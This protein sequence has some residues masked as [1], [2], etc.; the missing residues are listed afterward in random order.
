MKEQ[1]VGKF[2]DDK[3]N[4]L[5]SHKGRKKFMDPLGHYPQTRIGEEALDFQNLYLNL[6][7]LHQARKARVEL[8]DFKKGNDS[9]Q[10]FNICIGVIVIVTL[11]CKIIAS[12]YS[13]CIDSA[14]PAKKEKVE[15]KEIEKSGRLL[16]N[17]QKIA[18]DRTKIRAKEIHFV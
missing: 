12:T 6:E 9:F 17:M 18:N 11:I 7:S 13:Y 3:E 10:I 15:K 14:I 2:P 8:Q 4:G 5:Y 16:N 1:E